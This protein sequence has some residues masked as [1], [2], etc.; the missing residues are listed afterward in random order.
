MISVK[1]ISFFLFG[2]F[3]SCLS[4]H[5]DL[6][7]CLCYNKNRIDA[8]MQSILFSS[9]HL[10][11]L[12]RDEILFYWRSLRKKV[13][14]KFVIMLILERKIN[15]TAYKNFKKFSELLLHTCWSHPVIV[16]KYQHSKRKKKKCWK[17]F[18]FYW[19]NPSYAVHLA[20]SERVIF[21]QKMHNLQ[22]L[23][24]NKSK[25]LENY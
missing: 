3:S 22:V 18:F 13:P 16:S 2:E 20:G 25:V 15:F 7:H 23:E 9:C 17:I 10:S 1:T 6:L 8:L 24:N 21:S 19:H 5:N 14:T 4:F 11:P 12:W